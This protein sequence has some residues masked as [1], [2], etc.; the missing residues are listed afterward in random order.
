[1]LTT[2]IRKE[3]QEL[4]GST[5][6]ALAFGVCAVLILLSFYVG[7]ANFRLAQSQYEASQGE[8]LRQMEG[9][10]DW[11][12]LEQHRIFLPPE[13]LEALV[14]GISNDIGRTTEVKTRGELTAEDSRFN[15]DPIYAVFRF[16]DLSFVFQIVLSLF[17]ILL[18]YNAISGEK[19]RGT[20]RLIFA[21]AVP[22]A[23]FIL[24]K[25]IGTFVC[26][27][28]SLIVA[29]GLGC[30][31]LP[32]LGVNLVP[33]EWARLALVVLCGLL[34]FGAFLSLSVF[35]SAV[36]QRSSSSFLILL[37]VWIGAVLVIPR[38]SVMLA[39][40]A[41]DVPSVDELAAEKATF[42]RQLWKEF[43]DELSSY[44]APEFDGEEGMDAV[45]TQFHQFMDS[46]TARRDKK[47]DAFAERLN[48]RRFN[49]QQVQERLAFNIARIAPTA[50]LALATT[51]LAGTSLDL[52]DRFHQ[53]GTAY[54][55]TYNAFM[56]EKTGMNVGGRMIM[57]KSS[58]EDEEPPEPIDPTELP[59]FRPNNVPLGDTIE[60]SMIDIGLLGLFNLVFFAGAFLGFMRYDL[61]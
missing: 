56:K 12:S 19:E 39:G 36:T 59:A 20:L 60:A 41:V 34:Y 4:I 37:V 31:L 45:M 58:E 42:S 29:I 54:R 52:K 43:R 21:N 57:W 46:A 28:S 5:T 47:M 11:F 50:S 23:T 27:S 10:T 2:I 15:E 32:L 44:E 25:M 40:R 7:T 53:E 26:L 17:A 3:I 8:N 51:R 16:L 24:G 48:E 30:L 6:F 61:R 1:M 55:E 9:L 38:V 13:P 35:V 18:G 33:N 49:A 22:R 14:T